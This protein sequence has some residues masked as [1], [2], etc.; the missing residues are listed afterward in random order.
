M[1]GGAP[2]LLHGRVGIGQEAEVAFVVPADE[3][4]VPLG[5]DPVLAPG[6]RHGWVGQHGQRQTCAV[7]L[8]GA[9]QAAAENPWQGKGH[10]STHTTD[11]AVPLARDAACPGAS[12]G[13]TGL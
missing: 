10:R 12:T 4:H 5:P 2:T 7:A 6:W 1:A 9:E 8:P 3:R 11:A 13:E